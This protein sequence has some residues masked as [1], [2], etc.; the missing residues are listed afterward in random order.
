MDSIPPITDDQRL[1]LEGALFRAYEPLEALVAMLEDADKPC[2]PW[3]FGCVLEAITEAI[4]RR[5]VA[6]LEDAQRGKW[7]VSHE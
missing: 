6:I 5:V 1:L 7:K 3:K 2:E 4:D